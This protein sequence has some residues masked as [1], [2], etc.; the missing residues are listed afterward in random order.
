MHDGGTS[1]KM[2]V[3]GREVCLSKAIYGGTSTLIVDGKEWQ[4]IT[5]MTECT[6][7]VK[8]KKGEKIQV[9]ATYDTKNHPL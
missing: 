4:T 2:V 3:S 7:P 1:V 8:I 6:G 9:T 5:K